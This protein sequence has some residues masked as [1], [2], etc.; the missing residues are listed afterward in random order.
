MIGTT[1]NYDIFQGTSQLDRFKEELK[2]AYLKIDDRSLPEFVQFVSL[3]AQKINF[4]TAENSD[5]SAEMKNWG[6]FFNRDNLFLLII[7]SSYDLEGPKEK[8]ETLLDRALSTSDR[9][10]QI[11]LVNKILQLLL[12][13]ADTLNYIRTHLQ[14]TPL[15]RDFIFDLN[16]AIQNHLRDHL[17]QLFALQ[18]KLQWS[19]KTTK[20]FEELQKYWG[21]EPKILEEDNDSHELSSHDLASVKRAFH[22]F[23]YTAFHVKEVSETLLDDLKNDLKNNK[24]Y[25]ALFL[26]FVHLFEFVRDLQNELPKKH[27][28]HYYR[29]ILRLEERPAYPDRTSVSVQLSKGIESYLLPKNTL[30]SAGKNELEENLFYTTQNPLLLTSSKIQHLN[31][32][33]KSR[34]ARHHQ[35]AYSNFVTNLYSKSFSRKDTVK[36]ALDGQALFGDEKRLENN[37]D[38]TLHSGRIGCIVSSSLFRLHSGVRTVEVSLEFAEEGFQAMKESLKT[39]SDSNSEDFDETVYKTFS[40]GFQ[41]KISQED[42]MLAIDQYACE[43]DFEN[44]A[45]NFQFQL[46]INDKPFT[47]FQKNQTLNPTC[48][49]PFVEILLKEECYLYLYSI[50]EELQLKNIHIRTASAHLKDLEIYNQNGFVQ[51]SK[52]FEILGSI[53]KNNDYFIVG[54]REAFSKSIESISVQ[55][56]WANNPIMLGGFETYFSGYRNKKLQS[57]VAERM[58]TLDYQFVPSYLKNGS[59]KGIHL[60]KLELFKQEKKGHSN[61]SSVYSSDLSFSIEKKELN[62]EIIPYES[63][64]P[65]SQESNG[66][67]LKFTF[68]CPKLAFG[69]S[70]YA[71]VLSETVMYN[72]KLK[73]KEIPIPMPN[74]PFTPVIETVEMS[75]SAAGSAIMAGSNNENPNNVHFYQLSPFGYKHVDLKSIERPQPLF[76]TDPYEGNLLLGLDKVPVNGEITFLFDMNDESTNDQYRHGSEIFWSYMRN[77]EWV[78]F[79]EKGMM[80]DTT[81]GFINTGIIRLKIPSE[82][83]R[84]TSVLDNSLYWIRGSIASGALNLGKFDAIYENAVVVAWD[85]SCSSHH[86]T[87]PLPEHSIRALKDPIPEVSGIIQPNNS[88]GGLREEQDKDFYARVSERL[89]HK[90]RAVNAID[91][92]Q[93]V[94]QRFPFINKVKCFMANHTL[95]DN[96]KELGN[97]V[98]PGTVHLAVIPRTTVEE[99]VFKPKVSPKTL[100]SIQAFLSELVSPFVHVIVTNAHYEEI[101]VI[102]KVKFRGYE[103]SSYYEALLQKEITGYLSSWLSDNTLE[104]EFGKSIYKSDAMA[105]IQNL[106]FVD[107]VT[108]FS[109]VKIIQEN[110]YELYDTARGKEI[111][112]EI[113]VTYP[114]SILISA[115]KHNIQVIDDPAYASPKPRGIDNME[116]GID[117]IVTD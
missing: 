95:A 43:V 84:N 69:H 73:K 53:P 57:R 46:G 108:E 86:L 32:L 58:K 36:F 56:K 14:R 25:I 54:H 19:E 99:Q 109:M 102:C 64:K 81:N 9:D 42:Q 18:S 61:A 10:L 92:E 7:I 6:K 55:M 89:R 31:I 4:F 26:T 87:I 23:Y 16:S 59:W 66:G 8:I 106:Y 98:I 3:Y 112:E 29:D 41:I 103:S 80:N 15:T 74:Q 1:K 30:V 47:V 97:L 116:L 107:F 105:Y 93:L 48:T 13:I 40:T 20:K 50:A 110:G 114:W 63:H 60:S 91:Y 115:S 52:P 24:P 65:Y 71:H 78:P 68:T 51:H 62:S 70:E 33:Y 12:R 77:N 5:T 100:N 49:E 72:S 45:W 17:I 21:W 88:Y 37:H 113:W 90:G 67:F 22:S 82:I 101:R 94:L 39:I 35:K 111:E 27:L 44:N 83:N 85:R 96:Y 75:Y 117:F 38:D 28:D 2:N 11:K 76:H 79:E 104:E 34:D